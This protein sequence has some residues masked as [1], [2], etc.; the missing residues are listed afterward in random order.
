MWLISSTGEKTESFFVFKESN[1]LNKLNP[2]GSIMNIVII[3]SILRTPEK[4]IIPESKSIKDSLLY[5]YALSFHKLGH[6]VCLIAAKEYAPSELEEYPF[7]IIF[8][9]SNLK[10][11]FKPTMIPLHLDLFK[12]LLRNR[13]KI[14]LVIS[15]E[16]FSL[17]SLISS[18]CINTKKLIIWHELAVHNNKFFKLPSLLWYNFIARLFFKG[19][20]IVPRSEVASVFIK[21]YLKNISKEVVGHGISLEKF[22]INTKKEDCFISVS[23][24]IARKN[25]GSIIRK[26]ND[27]IKSDEKF[28][29]YKLFIV[30][31]GDELN[32][33][34]S[35]TNELAIKDSVIFCGQ[36]IH[37]ELNNL[38]GKSKCLLM[39]TLQ[40]NVV[41]VVAEAIA[42]AT[43]I[44]SNSIIDN[45]IL[46]NNYNVGI[47]KDE[48]TYLD[49]ITII[50]SNDEY[51]ENCINYRDNLSF[52][53]YAKLML[54]VFNE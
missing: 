29:H 31:G 6:D 30:G 35:L 24:L 47:A 19:T 32:N 4:G 14:D 40:D 51:V 2:N 23:Q 27:F 34:I 28:S 38:L 16:V 11:L 8:L 10:W 41:L 13:N 20:L 22:T 1:L 7:S 50:N 25:I 49:L 52:D 33:L 21:Q 44:L 43:P 48:W 26:F 12:Y 46:I 42:T 15:S 45:S 18:L 54:S 36:M 5:N 3:D 9:K 37:N 39:D 53:Y 17:N